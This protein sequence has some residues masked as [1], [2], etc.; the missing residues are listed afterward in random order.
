MVQFSNA[1]LPTNFPEKESNSVL[2]RG[3]QLMTF[4]VI[5]VDCEKAQLA[6][7]RLPG[8]VAITVL[9]FVPLSGLLTR[10][11]GCAT[12]YSQSPPDNVGVVGPPAGPSST[13]VN[14]LSVLFC[15]L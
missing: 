3:P 15:H 10:I 11:V 12:V 13:Q 7:V 8:V 5:T 2:R 1:L 6:L 9:N 4:K 14:P